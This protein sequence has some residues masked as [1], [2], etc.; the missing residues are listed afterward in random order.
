MSYVGEE[1]KTSALLARKLLKTNSSQYCALLLMPVKRFEIT[2]LQL[3]A[4][5]NFPP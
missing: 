5:F 3:Y 1:K 4:C 2:A